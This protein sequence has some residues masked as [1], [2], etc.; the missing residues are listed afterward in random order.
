[1]PSECRPECWL[2]HESPRHSHGMAERGRHHHAH[3]WPRLVSW[4]PAHG[5]V[6]GKYRPLRRSRQP[7]NGSAVHSRD[8]AHAAEG[9]HG[10]GDRS[11]AARRSLLAPL[12]RRRPAAAALGGRPRAGAAGFCLAAALHRRPRSVAG[13][14]IR[15][16]DPG[17]TGEASVSQGIETSSPA[18]GGP[19]GHSARG[20]AHG[21]GGSS[22]AGEASR[23]RGAGLARS[24]C[25][26]R[27]GAA[28]R[29]G[30]GNAAATSGVRRGPG[31]RRLR[32]RGR[33]GRQAVSETG[34]AAFAAAVFCT[35]SGPKS[36]AGCR[37][38]ALSRLWTCSSSTSNPSCRTGAISG[39]SAGAA[40]E[41]TADRGASPTAG[42]LWRDAAASSLSVA[43][44]A[45]T[46]MPRWW[47]LSGE[48][49]SSLASVTARF[50]GP[51]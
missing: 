11:A 32:R 27:A 9:G 17:H 4:H 44:C 22:D 21:D 23:A 25:A 2:C 8:D 16:A 10:G 47:R 24:R 3:G 50:L 5:A 30:S 18:P 41:C 19:S 1:M 39:L 49:S 43:M 31:G 38:D 37:A 26:C 36:H 15:P 28:S 6:L 29:R 12:P 45:G 40:S 35:C 20:A 51:P 46:G 42:C 48:L 14:A 33:L 13:D 34:S 7:N